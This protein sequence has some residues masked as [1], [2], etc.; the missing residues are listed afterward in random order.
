MENVRGFTRNIYDAFEYFSFRVLFIMTRFN[1]SPIRK[2]S[3][4]HTET[5]KCCLNTYLLKIDSFLHLRHTRVP[6]PTLKR[7]NVFLLQFE[8]GRP[9]EWDG[10]FA[11]SNLLSFA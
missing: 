10:A 6:F 2:C 1:S 4:Y 8:H 5:K 9:L 11:I 3:H 7:A